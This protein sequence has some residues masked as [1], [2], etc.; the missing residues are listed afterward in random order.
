MNWELLAVA[1]QWAGVF[2]VAATLFYLARQIRQQNISVMDTN[3]ANRVVGIRE[4]NANMLSNPDLRAAWNKA[5]GPHYRQLHEDIAKSLDVSFD[6]ASLIITQGTVWGYVHWA[7]YRSMKS[8]DDEAELKN[9]VRAWYS[10]N[11]MKA[12]LDH[13]N[14]K[15]YYDVDFTAWLD[16]TIAPG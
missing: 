10:E 15:A 1:G 14:F 16:E 8:P 6:E 7:Q 11:P 13:P 2:A 5:L 12:L 9:I 4:Q 3:R